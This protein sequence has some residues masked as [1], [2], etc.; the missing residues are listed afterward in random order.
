MKNGFLR[1]F[2]AYLPVMIMP[3]HSLAQTYWIDNKSYITN[4]AEHDNVNIPMYGPV[5]STLLITATHPPF[6]YTDADCLPDF[7][8]SDCNTICQD[9]NY[10]FTPESN[11]IYDDGSHVV[12][13]YS[14]NK[15]W[16]PNR[17]KV[18]INRGASAYGHY[19]AISK[20]IVNRNEWPQFLVLYCDSYLRLVPQPP[21]GLTKTCYGSS[22]IIG[23][24]EG[25]QAS[26]CVRPYVDIDSVLVDTVS[27]TS[28]SF[29]IWYHDGSTASAN[30]SVSI[31]EANVEIKT[32][33][34]S[35][36]PI[37]TF[38]SMWIHSVN[39]DADSISYGGGRFPLLSN[40]SSLQGSWFKIFRSQSSI[41]NSSAPDIKIAVLNPNNVSSSNFNI[42]LIY[43]LYQ[44]YPNPFN[45]STTMSFF[46]PS[47]QFISL[48][49]FD[50]LGKEVAIIISEELS[51]G[52]HTKQWNAD[53]MP[54]G[55]YFYRLCVGSF[56]ETRK[57]ILLR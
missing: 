17:M 55:V 32:N 48:K 16:R 46:L 24:A 2:I 33:F 25:I 29:K 54:S 51:A 27:T 45:P 57:L 14:E 39:C 31:Q 3:I 23:P 38:R 1:I 42:P 56:V 10:T 13:V 47:R 53:R 41:H 12:W 43:A 20:K 30:A 35:N 49:V 52:N 5:G 37:A 4:C 15:F 19:F 44:N 18:I 26:T 6:S 8:G 34:P 36:R 28:I 11:K 7:S 22:V 21:Q 50:V 40:W 9:S